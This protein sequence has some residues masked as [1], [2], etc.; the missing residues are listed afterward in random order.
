VIV[1]DSSVWIDFLN[2]NDG[3]QVEMLDR[4]LDRDTVATGDLI[5]TEVLQGIRDDREF[6]RVS[7]LMAALPS[8]EMAG[9][10]IA[11]KSAKNYRK[12]RAEGITVRKTIDLL[13]GTFCIEN[14]LTLLHRDRDFDVMEY[15]LGLK[16]L[17]TYTA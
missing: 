13:I 9:F 16:V 11:L 15:G 2:G 14:G 10:D 8:H 1:A 4:L 17:R 6:R 12:L 3:P 5:L 7:G